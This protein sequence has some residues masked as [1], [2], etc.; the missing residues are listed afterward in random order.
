LRW[1]Q[2]SIVDIVEKDELVARAKQTASKL[3]GELKS[4]GS[5]ESKATESSGDGKSAAQTDSKVPATAK[6]EVLAVGP[7]ACN[8]TILWSTDSLDALVVDPGGDGT[9]ILNVI[10]KHKLSVKQILVTHGRCL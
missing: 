10:N 9:K 1:R 2:V 3:A 6:W 4:A 5:T 7:L 8:C